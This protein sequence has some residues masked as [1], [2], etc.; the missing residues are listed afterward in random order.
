MRQQGKKFRNDYCTKCSVES[1]EKE[2][3]FDR[4]FGGQAR[5]MVM[6]LKINGRQSAFRVN[7]RPQRQPLPS[8]IHPTNV[9]A[10]DRTFAELT[11]K[12]PAYVD[13]IT[14]IIVATKR[15]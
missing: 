10:Q 13:F 5:D 12:M 4:V 2:N 15:F 11:I 8:T 6:R 7:K 14:L 9:E 1:P 3:C